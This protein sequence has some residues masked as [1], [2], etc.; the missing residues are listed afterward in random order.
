M[1]DSF[2]ARGT[3]T[4]VTFGTTPKELRGSDIIVLTS[5]VPWPHRVFGLGTHLD[6]MRLKACLAEFFNVHVSEHTR[7]IGYVLPTCKRCP[8]YL[9]RVLMAKVT[10]VDP[11]ADIASGVWLICS[12]EEEERMQYLDSFR[13]GYSACSV[14]T[15]NRCLIA[16]V[17]DP[18]HIE[19][20]ISCGYPSAP[21][22]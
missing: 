13:R 5:G 22:I 17:E 7:I 21:A 20:T 19:R 9:L 14:L 2:A 3:N 12:T 15:G 8:N 16:D 18:Y 11:D 1:M 6:S 10:I 4:R